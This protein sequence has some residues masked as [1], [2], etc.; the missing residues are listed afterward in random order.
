MSSTEPSRPSFCINCKAP[1]NLNCA[2]EDCRVGNYDRKYCHL[3]LAMYGAVIRNEGLSRAHN[4]WKNDQDNRRG[5][6]GL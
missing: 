6:M 5:R 4:E 3:C 1:L 2:C